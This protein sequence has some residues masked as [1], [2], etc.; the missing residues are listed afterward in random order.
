[1]APGQSWNHRRQWPQQPLVSPLHA[2]LDPPSPGDTRGH[3]IPPDSWR[4]HAFWDCPIALSV[5]KEINA[6]LPPTS[7]DLSPVT[8]SGC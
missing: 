1:M 5:R 2:C 6:S 7:C 8:I 3:G 4:G